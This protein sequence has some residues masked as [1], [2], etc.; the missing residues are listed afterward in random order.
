[1]LIIF[2][3]SEAFK[4]VPLNGKEW[5]L[6]IGLGAI[7]LPWGA[8]I[9]LFPDAWVGA[10]LPKFMH[11]KQ[12]SAPVPDKVEK[13]DLGEFKPP[14]RVMS[15]LRGPKVKRHIGFRERVHDV[16]VKAID[17][18]HHKGSMDEM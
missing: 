14:L 5:G 9:R 7:S 2:V 4:I 6:S 12:T 8:L 16:K 10:M 18:V 13:K 17:K 11:K 15:A 3:G 1:M